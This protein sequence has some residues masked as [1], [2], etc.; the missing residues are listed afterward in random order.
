MMLQAY[1]WS[2]AWAL[3]PS[4][5]PTIG[6]CGQTDYK[7]SRQGLSPSCLLLASEAWALSPSPRSTIGHC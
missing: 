2:A 7:V 3:S 6:R 1:Y 5:R 4:P